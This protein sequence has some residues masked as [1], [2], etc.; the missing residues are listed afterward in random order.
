MKGNGLPVQ[1]RAREKH[2]Q[3]RFANAQ[4][5]LAAPATVQSVGFVTGVL[6]TV[7]MLPA[8]AN[9]GRVFVRTDL[10]GRPRI[11]ATIDYAVDRELRTSLEAD[12][13]VVEMTEHLL[14]ALAGLGIDNC[15]IEID[16]PEVP[17]VD[18]SAA[19]FVEAIVAAGIVT[20]DAPRDPWCVSHGCQVV[21]GEAMIGLYPTNADALDITFNLDYENPG[22][23]SQS[24]SL[25]IQPA[26]FRREIAPARTF[27]LER[28]VARLR[29][30][31]LG[32]R[33]SAA[34]LLVFAPDG[35]LID[36]Q[37]RFPDECVRHKILDVIGDLALLGR[38]IQGHVLAHKSGHRLNA[39]LAR[40]LAAQ[41]REAEWRRA[42]ERRPL[43]DASQIEKII[44]HRFPFLLV[45][46]V[47]HLEPNRRAVGVKNVS[48]NEPFFQG[49]W[50]G[51]PI[52]PGVL[53]VE[54][55]AQLAGILLTDWQEH[56]HYA[57]IISMDG[58]KLRRPVIP[59]DQ[60]VLEAESVRVKTR[61][62]TL[63]TWAR[64]GTETVAEARMNFVHMAHEEEMAA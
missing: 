59:G 26:T 38:P 60:L 19:P 5:T 58:I 29:A 18:G 63:R 49:H 1:A 39:A 57:M 30:A 44:P 42:F 40:Q 36:N 23:G 9:S 46:R 62:A 47:L 22:I 11:P 33:S 17:A 56:G 61:I 16:G 4:T 32:S 45:D 31:G 15:E 35:R 50:P 14:A 37:L 21:D 2:P 41:S 53:V 25:R 7:R 3:P 20:Q 43:L 24:R 48:Y 64:I 55:M 51:R 8:P 54:A 6:V 28:D 52:M 34:D 12:G 27:V 10:P 13:A